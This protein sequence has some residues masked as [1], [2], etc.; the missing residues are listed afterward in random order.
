MS[1]SRS[2]FGSQGTYAS[3][4]HSVAQKRVWA[5]EGRLGHGCEGLMISNLC[6]EHFVYRWVSNEADERL[7]YL[8]GERMVGGET[9]CVANLAVA[10][11]DRQGG[12]FRVLRL[13]GGWR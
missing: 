2:S 4:S 1:L 12:L 9:R 8:C 3:R 11:R 13:T 10:S 5:K 7:T 6:S